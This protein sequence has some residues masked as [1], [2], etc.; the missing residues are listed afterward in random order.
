MNTNFLTEKENEF[1]GFYLGR[2]VEQERNL[3]K[4]VTEDGELSAEVSGK[5]RYETLDSTDFPAVGD[6]VLLDRKNAAAG[7][8]LIHKRLERQSVLIR[9]AAGTVTSERQVIAANIDKIFICMALNEDFNLRRAERY[10]ALT[11]ESGATPVLILTKQDLC[12]DLEEKLSD[13]QKIA[14]GVKIL[15]TSGLDAEGYFPLSEE[16]KSGQTVAFIGSSGVGKSTLINRL[17]GEEL[18]KTSGLGV[19][20]KGRH[21]TTHRKLF[22]LASGAMVIDTPGMREL[23]LENANFSESFPDIDELALSC[24]FSDCS[25][26][27]EPGC[28]VLE[29]IASGELTTERLSNYLKM[30]KESGYDGLTSRQIQLAKHEERRKELAGARNYRK[31]LHDRAKRR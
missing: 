29:A 16:I 20:S 26:K 6:F 3:Y 25:H 13:L 7:T 27:N 19:D 5:F 28:A 15:V 30:K 23:G 4:V 1:P 8:A 12:D 11:W 9:K 10:L 21:T 14:L 22:T 24:K 31:I 17:L 2:V 18:I